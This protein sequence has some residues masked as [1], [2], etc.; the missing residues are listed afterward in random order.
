MCNSS[1]LIFQI[2][3]KVSIF[4]KIYLFILTADKKKYRLTSQACRVMETILKEEILASLQESQVMRSIQHG[5]LPNRSCL[6]NLL[7][8]FDV[9]EGAQLL[10]FRLTFAWVST[11]FPTRSYWWRCSLWETTLIPETE[12][13]LVKLRS[14]E[15]RVGKECCW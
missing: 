8:Y 4:I 6:T 9:D 13:G 3:M 14:E 1:L 7:T 2:Q 5:F 15:R 10:Q 12:S 11:L